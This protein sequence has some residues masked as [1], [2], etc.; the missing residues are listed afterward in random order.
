MAVDH[1]VT[2]TARTYALQQQVI[3]ETGITDE[4][5]WAVQ[6]PVLTD[7]MATGDYPAIA[8]LPE[9]AFSIDGE[10]ALEFGLQP[11]LDGLEAFIAGRVP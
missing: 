7:A 11:L 5:F 4:E 1:Y 6:E 10:D 9:D 8:Q 2:G 3:Q